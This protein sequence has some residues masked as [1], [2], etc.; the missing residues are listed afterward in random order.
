MGLDAHAGF[1]KPMPAKN[2]EPIDVYDTLE[3]PYYWRKHA[4]LQQFMMVLWHEKKGEETPLGVMG[5]DFNGG[6]ILW[7]LEE[8]ILKLQDA[9]KTDNLPFCPDGFFW[10]HQFQ[11]E[12]MREY[13]QQDLEFCEKALKW[14]EEGKNVFYDCSW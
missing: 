14:L 7:L 2:V 3:A 6:N 8:D 13:K 11:E 1:Q 9:V 4:R 5:S 12:S 10:G